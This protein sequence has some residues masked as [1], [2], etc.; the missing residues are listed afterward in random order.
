M[1][2]EICSKQDIDLLVSSFLNK[3]HREPL[4]GI[5][6]KKLGISNNRKLY[7][8][9]IDFWENTLIYSGEYSGNPIESYRQVNQIFSL[10]DEHFRTWLSLFNATVDELFM[11][12][13]A[14]LAKQ[15]AASIS[16]VIKSK[17]L[18]ALMKKDIS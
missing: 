17:T 6:L 1:K 12:G 15:R 2:K 16:G 14:T 4:T 8:S 3:L 7:H 10:K 9:M 11:G 13:K 18:D 5:L